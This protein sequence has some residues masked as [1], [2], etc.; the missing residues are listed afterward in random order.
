MGKVTAKTN[1]TLDGQYG[2]CRERLSVLGQVQGVGFRPFVYRLA[3]QLHLHGRVGNDSHGAFIEI[4]GSANTIAEFKRR[5]FTE[6]PPLA[7]IAQLQTTPMI[8]RHDEANFRIEASVDDADCQD[9]EMTPDVALCAE[10]RAEL[11][12]PTNRRYHYPFINCTNCGPRYSIIRNVPYDRPNTTM[13]KFTMCPACQ[14]EYNTPTNR[15]FHAQPNA[16]Q[17]CGPRVWFQINA[18]NTNNFP[19]QEKL[20]HGSIQDQD[21]IRRCV[22]WLQAGKIVAIKSI[23]GFHLACR[24]DDDAAV[25]MLRERKSR[26]TKPLAIMATNLQTAHQLAEIDATAAAALTDITRPIVLVSRKKQSHSIANLLHVSSFVAPGADL[27][28]LMLPYTPLHEL[29][30]AE[31]LGPVVMTSGNPS[32]EPLCCDNNEALDRLSHIADAFLLYD[33][34]IERRID[35]SVILAAPLSTPSSTRLMPIRRARGFAPAPI[36]VPIHTNEPILAVGAELKSTICMLTGN[37]AV[38]SEHLGELSNVAAYRHFV[39]TIEQ[40]Q[41]LLRIRPRAIA[42]DLHPDY[43]ST[44]FALRYAH[45]FG[46]PAIGVQHHHAHIVSAMAENELTGR[47]LGIACDGTGF[48]TDNTGFSVNSAIWGCE[49]LIANEQDFTRVG[50]LRYVPLLGGDAAARETWR[51]AVALLHDAFG[52]QWTQAAETILNAA[53]LDTIPRPAMDWARARL[54]HAHSAEQLPRTSSLGRL[55][56]GVAFLLGLANANHH[57]AQA[58]MAL[59]SAARRAPFEKSTKS[60]VP[61]AY[62]IRESRQNQRAGRDINQDADQNQNH[63]VPLELSVLELDV[64]PMIRELVAAQQKGDHIAASTAESTA[65]LAARFHETITSGLAEMAVIV[66]RREGL[67]RVVLSGGCFANQLLLRSLMERLVAAG[68]QV[69]THREIPTGDGGISLGQAVCAAARMKK[70]TANE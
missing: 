61:L 30:F 2:P 69:I 53:S 66:A 26:E 40:F 37:T 52:K 56:D 31:G 14:A 1:S 46:L 45:E 39:A 55:F 60:A 48:G 3:Q 27:L 13:A 32:E 11:F 42:Y 51:P 20:D 64:R 6:L 57:E 54:A 62:K 23:G 28:G 63:H 65:T 7:R 59:E 41:R 25:R 8:C 43:S 24:A 4:Q 70:A 29:L 10:C 33:R 44:R 58:A 21:P 12:D 17:D 9:A 34:D 67:Q 16:C 22:Q 50:H 15:R 36:R 47:V 35:D 18:I 38:V 49:L 19:N 68:L 5:L